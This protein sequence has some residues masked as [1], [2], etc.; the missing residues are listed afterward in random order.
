MII[1]KNMPVVEGLEVTFASTVEVV[2][3]GTSTFVR[4]NIVEE[5]ARVALVLA[6]A[7]IDVAADDRNC[8]KPCFGKATS[9]GNVG[10]VD[11]NFDMSPYVVYISSICSV[12]THSN[13]YDVSYLI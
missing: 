7:S 10:A 13:K 2:E 3:G 9:D 8:R 12:T 11:N 1:P 6:P 5:G 4:L